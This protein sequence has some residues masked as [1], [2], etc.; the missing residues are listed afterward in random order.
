M[1][2][3]YLLLV[4]SHL[5]ELCCLADSVYINTVRISDIL[6]IK[7]ISVLLSVSVIMVSF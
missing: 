4:P 3:P 1:Q 5:L 7:I 6:V 2:D